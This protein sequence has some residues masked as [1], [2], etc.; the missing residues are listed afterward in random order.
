MPDL[1]TSKLFA[2]LSDLPSD[3]RIASKL[4]SKLQCHNLC[5]FVVGIL[6]YGA[7]KLLKVVR[8]H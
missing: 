7:Y 8:D 1:D 3:V 5:L 2:L 4:S 6:F